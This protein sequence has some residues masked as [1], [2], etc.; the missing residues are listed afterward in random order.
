VSLVMTHSVD[1][2]PPFWSLRRTKKNS[3]EPKKSFLMPQKSI[4]MPPIR[5]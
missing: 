3:S 1:A 4:L 5:F 2:R